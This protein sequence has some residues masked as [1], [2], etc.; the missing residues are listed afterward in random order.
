MG[1]CKRTCRR[2]RRRGLWKLIAVDF[3]R[4]EARVG[5]CEEDL[6][7]DVTSG[8]RDQPFM[9]LIHTYIQHAKHAT[10]KRNLTTLAYIPPKS[11]PHVLDHRAT[12]PPYSARSTKTTC[13]L[14]HHQPCIPNRQ[15]RENKNPPENKPP[16]PLREKRARSRS[17]NQ[18]WLKKAES[19]LVGAISEQT[20]V[21]SVTSQS[22]FAHLARIPEPEAP[23]NQSNQFPPTHPYTNLKQPIHPHTF[24]VTPGPPPEYTPLAPSAC[25]AKRTP[26]QWFEALLFLAFAL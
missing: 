18:R 25:R 15:S 8:P 7:V 24:P 13:D 14:Q 3:P 11:Q 2:E 26:A 10:P 9:P 17:G 22:Y 12:E 21:L 16:L 20:H 5:D 1:K 23:H 19:K 4:T 6:A